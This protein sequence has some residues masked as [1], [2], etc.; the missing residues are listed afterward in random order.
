LLT[1]SFSLN[2]SVVLWLNFILENENLI[3]DALLLPIDKQYRALLEPLRFDYMDMK[4]GNDYKHHYK[5]LINNT[6]TIPQTKMIRLAQELA[7][8]SN[9]LPCNHSDAAYV[10]VDKARVDMMKALIC[11]AADTPYAHGC[12][13]FDIFM[14]NTYPS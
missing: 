8:L 3:A 10:R 13:E 14:E 5:S 11:G 6:Q 1:T 7:D 12:Y 9:A 2:V 4:N